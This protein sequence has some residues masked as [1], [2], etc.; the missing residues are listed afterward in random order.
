[1]KIPLNGSPV[2]GSN[3]KCEIKFWWSSWSQNLIFIFDSIFDWFCLIFFLPL[4]CF[5]VHS[6]RLY[7]IFFLHYVDVYN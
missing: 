3:N 2:A 7:W 6:Q 1:L 4:S 5:Y